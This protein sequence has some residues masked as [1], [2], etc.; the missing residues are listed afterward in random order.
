MGGI[1][2]SS[3]FDD[4]CDEI[5]NAQAPEDEEEEQ[6]DDNESSDEEEGE[7]KKAKHHVFKFSVRIIA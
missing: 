7:M 3:E 4:L 2:C 5:E 6:Q 1:W